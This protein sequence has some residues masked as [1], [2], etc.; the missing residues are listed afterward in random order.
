MY[1]LILFWSF[2]NKAKSTIFHF[3]SINKQRNSLAGKT[4]HVG[5]SEA[6]YLKEHSLDFE[7]I[8]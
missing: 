5:E 7:H 2:I 1:T 4:H 6:M 3:Q 8:L